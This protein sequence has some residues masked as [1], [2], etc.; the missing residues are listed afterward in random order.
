MPILSGDGTTL[1]GRT[2][3]VISKRSFG[4]EAPISVDPDR[5]PRSLPERGF[6]FFIGMIVSSSAGGLPA[7]SIQRVTRRPTGP[8]SQSSNRAEGSEPKEYVKA[9]TR[10]D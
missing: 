8:R 2:R 5:R 7:L 3:I 6:D 1:L 10:L 4:L 9:C